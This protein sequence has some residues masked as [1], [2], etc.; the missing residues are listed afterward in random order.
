MI[1]TVIFQIGNVPLSEVFSVSYRGSEGKNEKRR[2]SA[3]HF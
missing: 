3:K 1:D 2:M